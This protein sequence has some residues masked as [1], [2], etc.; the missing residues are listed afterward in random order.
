[1]SDSLQE[2]PTDETAPTHPEL[3]MVD[4]LFEKNGSQHKINGLISEFKVAIFSSILFVIF[5]LSIVDTLLMN[6]VSV[7]NNGVIRTIIKAILFMI[8]VY[9]FQNLS[10]I[11]KQE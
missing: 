9:T 4:Y 10:F 8:L 1:M 6:I 11:R 5:S 2:L 3:K 7:A